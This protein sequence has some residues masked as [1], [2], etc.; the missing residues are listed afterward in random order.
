MQ[1]LKILQ[2]FF[3]PLVICFFLFRQ[4]NAVFNVQFHSY[5]FVVVFKSKIPEELHAA[6]SQSHIFGVSLI[7]F[8]Q[9]FTVLSTILL[10]RF[11]IYLD[12][13]GFPTIPLFAPTKTRIH[14]C[15]EGAVLQEI[16]YFAGWPSSFP[17]L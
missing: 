8:L 9:V 6:L 16:L 12:G 5:S 11:V 14:V 13:V 2:Q 15:E 17:C 7:V 1:L 10:I 4:N 3:G